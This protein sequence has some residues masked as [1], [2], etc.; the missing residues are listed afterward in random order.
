MSRGPVGVI[1]AGGTGTRLGLDIPKQLAR[2]D[3]RT[4]LEI[5]VSAMH[6]C[7]EIETMHVMMARGWVDE[8]RREL[9][10]RFPKLVGVHEGG[11]TRNETTQKVL[12]VLAD[13]DGIVLLHDA[14]RPFLDC[15]IIHECVRELQV[16]DAVDVA[17]PS[18]DTIVVVDERDVISDIPPRS[19]LRRGQTPQ[20]FRTA[21]LRLAYEIALGDPDFVATDDCGVVHQY[22]PGVPIKVIP[23]AEHNMKV[24]HPTDLVVAESLR[25]ARARAA[26]APTTSAIGRSADE[27]SP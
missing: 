27:A 12:D 2:L 1:L 19:T 8:A 5:S 21:V 4:L 3:G 13:D 24:T 18:A 7:A 11:A 16:Y 10:G 15:T 17:I 6:Q 22:L 14:V 26:G 20:G 23:G 25:V 9:D